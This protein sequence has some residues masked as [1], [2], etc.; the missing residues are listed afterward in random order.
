MIKILFLFISILVATIFLCL[1]TVLNKKEGSSLKKED[2]IR[3]AVSLISSVILSGGV[4]V[5]LREYLSIYEFA[6]CVSILSLIF[7]MIF[8]FIKKQMTVDIFLIELMLMGIGIA[9][10]SILT[11]GQTVIN[12]DVATGSLQPLAQRTYGAMFPQSWVCANGDIW[13][14]GFSTFTFPFTTLMN[15][16]PLARMLGSATISIAVMVLIVLFMKKCLKSKAYTLA[17]V[18]WF[19]MLFGSYD[20]ILYQAAY[21]SS[22]LNMLLYLICLYLVF[23]DN[24]KPD[25]QINYVIWLICNI[26]LFASS[27]MRWGAE[28]LIPA[29]G[30]FIVLDY[31]KIRNEKVIDWK[32]VIVNE[33][34]KLFGILAPAAIGILV[35]RILSNYCTVKNTSN[36][37]AIFADNIEQLAANFKLVFW[38]W[39]DCFGFCGGAK[40]VSFE[41]IRN[42]CSICLCILVC[43]I[44]PLL[45]ARRIKDEPI[46]YQWFYCFSLIHIFEMFFIGISFGKLY[47]YYLLTSVFLFITIAAYYVYK[48]LICNNDWKK[49]VWTLGYTVVFMIYGIAILMS[50]KNWTDTLNQKTEFNDIIKTHNV[51]KGYA[52]FWNAYEN[53]VYSNFDITYGAVNFYDV[54]LEAYPWLV[55]LNVFKP[56]NKKSFLLMTDEELNLIKPQLEVICGIPLEMFELDNK[57]IYIFDHDIAADF[58]NDFE[59]GILKPNEIRTEGTVDVTHDEVTI[60]EDGSCFVYITL[61]PGKYVID[62]FGEN[63]NNLMYDLD[64]EN[65]SVEENNSE[66]KLSVSISSDKDC[67]VRLSFYNKDQDKDTIIKYLTLSKQ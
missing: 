25:K 18:L 23:F 26:V 17:I 36:N 37:S 14:L 6:G 4:Y 28:V 8:R 47:S 50:S 59:D 51:D 5:C 52:Q 2:Y 41:G 16:Q 22:M 62:F 38:N 24:S 35:Y 33:G 54:R 9:L 61:A 64:V 20:M 34:K 48:Y 15:N 56:E 12:S 66:D 65:L 21:T 7:T 55:D 58:R 67:T 44:F 45:Q 49:Y 42:I 46:E 27:S 11:Y 60:K 13:I 1:E 30:A 63:V 31:L 29:I 57:W 43:V 19:L 3:V 53:S 39:L 40:A 32:S 10:Y